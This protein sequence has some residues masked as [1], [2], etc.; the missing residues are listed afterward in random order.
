VRP[1]HSNLISLSLFSDPCF[2]P[3]ALDD[4]FVDDE[5]NTL[6]HYVMA[7]YIFQTDSWFTAE[8]LKL[9]DFFKSVTTEK[10][11]MLSQINEYGVSAQA[12]AL[13]TS[14]V[15]VKILNRLP[16]L[17]PVRSSYWSNST[18][19]EPVFGRLILMRHKIQDLESNPA[20]AALKQIMAAALPS[21]LNAKV[22]GPKKN[23]PFM[24]AAVEAEAVWVRT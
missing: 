22:Y 8:A 2:F 16:A 20:H 9:V 18:V 11:E 10:P 15:P 23:L 5:G 3:A 7:N 13:G 12:L 4:D 14:S 17:P 24:H 19:E 21:D 6:L 1:N